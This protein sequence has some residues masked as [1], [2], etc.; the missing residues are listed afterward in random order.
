MAHWL[1]LQQVHRNDLLLASLTGQVSDTMDDVSEILQMLD[2]KG[3][4]ALPA[5]LQSDLDNMRVM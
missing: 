2:S 5:G 1:T 4:A 3:S